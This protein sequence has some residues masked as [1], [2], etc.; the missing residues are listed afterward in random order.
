M[1][2]LTVIKDFVLICRFVSAN[3]EILT[4]PC[5]I[6]Q[7]F[8]LS[9]AV[10]AGQAYRSA[11]P[12]C[13]EGWCF[14]SSLC[15]VLTSFR[16]IYIFFKPLDR[17]I[18]NLFHERKHIFIFSIFNEFQ[19]PVGDL[20]FIKAKVVPLVD[21]EEEVHRGVNKLALVIPS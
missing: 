11:M 12:Y 16:T 3:V 15:L 18:A 9:F 4:F 2:F 10:R 7:F 6:S 19:L 17:I 1:G 21:G 5:I 8:Y 14:R 13:N 20:Y